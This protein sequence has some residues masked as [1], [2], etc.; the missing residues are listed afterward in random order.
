MAVRSFGD[1]HLLTN[2]CLCRRLETRRRNPGGGVCWPDM[3]VLKR[4][5]GAP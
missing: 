5:L 3:L 4:A 2:I 1:G